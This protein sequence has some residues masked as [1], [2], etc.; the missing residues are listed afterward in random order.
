MRQLNAKQNE[1]S[2]KN[3]LSGTA[4]IKS[5][6]QTYLKNPYRAA[7]LAIDKAETKGLIHKNASWW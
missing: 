2:V 3:Q 6:K 1:N 4:A 5:L 7:A